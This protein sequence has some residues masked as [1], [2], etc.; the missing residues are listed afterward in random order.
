MVCKSGI[1][2]NTL[3]IP[4]KNQENPHNKGVDS[5]IL[6]EKHEGQLEGKV[7]EQDLKI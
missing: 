1:A 7:K 4:N 6:T 5:E 3:P 2:N